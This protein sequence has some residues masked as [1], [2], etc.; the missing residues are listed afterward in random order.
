MTNFFKIT[1]IIALCL[2]MA[3]LFTGPSLGQ[4]A[5][6]PVTVVDYYNLLPDVNRIVQK[7]GAWKTEVETEYGSMRGIMVDARNGYMKV[8]Y[9]GG[10]GTTTTEAA[11]FLKGD[12]TP[13]L[14]VSQEYSGVGGD[15]SFHFYEFRE[16]KPVEVTGEV[17]PKIGYKSFFDEKFDFSRAKMLTAP[18]NDAGE[19]NG[20][21]IIQVRLTLPR[22]GT[23]VK[24]SLYI[25][26]VELLG[27]DENYEKII[28]ELKSKTGYGEI[29]ITWNM[30]KGKFEMGKKTVK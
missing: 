20:R 24:A 10:D 19:S 3:L 27:L 16:K 13:V 4:K 5:A 23:G 14:G 26:Q 6:R 25:K 30:G 7:C 8:T 17:L 2:F 29:E 11:L 9:E 22:V 21:K 18:L 1:P 28:G 12:K 15:Y